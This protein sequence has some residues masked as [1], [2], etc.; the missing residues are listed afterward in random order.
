MTV[1]KNVT[2]DGADKTY[3]GKMTLTN[4]ADITI[5]NVNF[6]GK[7][8]NGYAVE[9][10]G[11]YYVTIEDCTA[12]NYGYGFVQLA[13]GTVLTT[14]KNVTVSDMN[15]GV[16]I[17]YSNAVV[18]ENV[19][20]DCTVAAV[21]NSNYGEKTVTIKNSDLSIL[22]TWTRN[23]TIKT[24][25]VFEGENTVDEFI[26]DAAI[27]TFKLADVNSTLTAPNDITVTTD[28]ADHEVEYI[29][30][31]YTVVDIVRV[32]K[33]GE[34]QYKTLAAAIAAAKSGDT[35]TLL[36]D[37]TEDVTVN[38]NVTIDGANFKYTG[39][40]TVSNGKTVTVQNVNFVKGCIDKTKGT[41]GTLTVKAC[42]FDGVD[43]SINYAVTMRGGSTVTM[44]G[45]TVKN[46]GYGML[47]VPS[48]VSNVNVK[49]VTVDGVNYG[50]HVAYGSKINL[51]NVTM[52]NVAYGIMTQN[53]GAKTIT[54]KN[55][56][57]S[58]TNPIYVW[59]RN[60]T[61]VDTFNFEGNNTVSA[62][63]TSAQAKL[64]LVAEDA[65]VTAPE[66]ANVTTDVADCE[67]EYIDGTYTVVDIVRVAQIGETQYKTLAAAIAAAQSGE[68][69]T[70]LTDITEDVTVNKSVTIDGANFKYTGNI[71]VEG[72]TTAVTVKNVNFVNGTGY[73]ITTNRIK[74]ITVENCTVSNYGYGFLYANKS[75]PT[76]VVKNVTV[77]G[78]NYGMHWVYGSNATLEN[79]TMTNVVYGLYI[80][81][82]AGKT[83]NVKN[84]EITSIGIWERS[85]YSGVQTFKFEGEN[86]VG[87]LTDSE[88]AK[89]VLVAEDATV[90]APEG[91]NV[92]TTVEGCKVVYE[93]GMYKVV[94]LIE[95]A[96]ANVAA[97]ESLRMNFYVKK[98]DL[99]GEGYY[100]V[101]VK[102]F[103]D[104]RADV[105]KTIDFAD[106]ENY[107]ASMYRFGFS[108]ISAK[109]M[110]DL[111]YVTI[112]N[113][114][115]V[116]VSKEYID[117]IRLY[118]NRNI[119][120]DTTTALLRTAFVDML[121]YGAAAQKSF[122]YDTGN[123]ANADIDS[124]QQYAT[125]SVSY[126][127]KL[128]A[129]ENYVGSTV[130][131]SDQMILTFYFKNI[132]KDMTATITYTDHYGNLKETT[133][134]GDAFVKNGTLYGVPV[135]QRVANGRQL[136][137]CEVKDANGNIVASATDSIESYCARKAADLG[138]VLNCLMKFVESAKNYFDSTKK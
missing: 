78:G 119:G 128:V 85:G 41:S 113:E 5:K 28:V 107:N 17:D 69:I 103:A 3:T 89:Y 34:T 104:G 106:W 24:N 94:G 43:G 90:T 46:Y 57:L 7:G 129:G 64:V 48:A 22:G 112:Y 15:Y 47:Y 110:S 36:G 86:K 51:D 6:D 136:V 111:I 116:V 73:A 122:G 75:T 13:S 40:M 100:A 23:D 53:Y 92:T 131:A 138:D 132:T 65:T 70:F 117:S 35:I 30:G 115:D 63:P 27:D 32:A 84:S 11:A 135:A 93:N 96:G 61:V 109:E 54:I 67:V 16:K 80:Q 58:G 49:N 21:L 87:T 77:D 114:D 81:N 59:E 29:N 45:C 1:N 68:T 39:T 124:Y 137:T 25:I 121:N 134:Q 97:H 88:Y 44:E 79:V 98:A 18:L 31:T 42:D 2:I 60:T 19:K 108:D 12:K 99:N 120:K 91:A 4:K 14:V 105:T 74:S 125:P 20:A 38:K 95:I 71:S 62:L 52:T 127:N 76:V 82:Y 50:V 72:S 102:K 66:G 37:V 123:L 56:N 55:S 101:I 118:V 33:I 130:T 26:I 126:E 133:V 8:Y 10:R 83:I 9:A